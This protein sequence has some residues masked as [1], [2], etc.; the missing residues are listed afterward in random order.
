AYR[1][2]HDDPDGALLMLDRDPDKHAKDLGIQIFKW[3]VLET[4]RDTPKIEPLLNHLIENFPEEPGFRKILVQFYLQQHRQDDAEKAMRAIVTANP[5]N[6]DAQLDVVR[7]LFAV[8]GP[9]AAREELAKLVA[10]G[11]DV[12]PYEMALADLDYTQGRAGDSVALLDKLSKSKDSD[13]HLRAAKIK[14]AEQ[15]IGQKDYAAAEQGVAEILAKDQRNVSALRLRAMIRLAQGQ[16][17]PA[18]TD[19]REAIGQQPGSLEL[20]RLLIIAYEQNGSVELA[21]EAFGKVTKVSNFAPAVGLEYVAFLQRHGKGDRAEDLLTELSNHSP[22][23]VRVLAAL[24]QA[25]LAKHDWA[26]AQQIAEALRKAGETS[27]VGNQILGEAL[28]GQK[29]YDLSIDV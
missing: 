24:A 6:S 5:A 21:D 12:F 28:A 8:K 20:Q 15:Q 25:K 10:G 7:F 26:G 13:E 9:D 27:A 18:I 17:D 22:K 23:D 4:K 2:A 16:V 19:L 29:Q 14:L 3:K 1:L 11:G